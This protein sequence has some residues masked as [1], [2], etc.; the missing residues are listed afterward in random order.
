MGHRVEK[1]RQQRAAIIANT[2]AL[3]RE[4]GAARI[5]ISD[6]AACS[7]I[8]DATFF[9]YFASKDAVLREWADGVV[10]AAFAE[11]AERQ[12]EGMA[13][14]RAVRWLADRLAARAREEGELLGAG[15]RLARVVPAWDEPGPARGRP[16]TQDAARQL[17]EQARDRGEVRGDVP[18]AELGAALRAVVVS[19]LVQGLSRKPGHAAGAPALAAGA[20]RAADVL[21]DGMRKRNERVRAPLPAAPERGRSTSRP[22]A[23]TPTAPD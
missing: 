4:S 19:A 8:S 1:Q 9:N 23:S 7:G 3:I 21:L 13:L 5:R 15:L 14:R 17:I 6:I 18:A 2:L 11:A 10:D 20:R 16:R 12:A 22:G